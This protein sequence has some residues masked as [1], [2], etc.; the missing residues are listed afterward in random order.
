MRQVVFQ[1]ME[2]EG[3]SSFFLHQINGDTNKLG[4]VKLIYSFA[5]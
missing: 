3:E 5:S 1:S 2:L 4:Q